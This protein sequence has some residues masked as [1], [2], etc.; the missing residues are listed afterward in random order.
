MPGREMD[1]AVVGSGISGLSAAWLLSKRHRV[2]VYEAAARPG[3]HSNTVEVGGVAV[4]TGFI[5][6]N[7]TTYPNLTALF[8][9]L[10]VP[11][12]A[13]EMSFAVSLDNGGL[14]YAGTDLFGLFG[15]K[16]NVVRPRFWSMLADLRRFYAEAPA[17]VA[18]LPA[19]TTL[20]TFLDSEGYGQA[21][22]L[23]H[24]LP[25]AAAIWSA[26]AETLRDYP[27][28][29]FIRFCANHGLLKFTDR[30][31]WRTVDG[32]SREYV[33]RLL[34][35]IG[36]IRLARGAVSVRRSLGSVAVRDAMGSEQRFDHV[37]MACHAD[38]ALAALEAPTARERTLLGAF[39]Y[40]QN[41][42]V[43]HSDV[44][45][46]PKRRNVWAS[47]NYLGGRNHAGS[48][49]VTYWMNRLQGLAG[50]PPLFVTLN[51]A[52]E[53]AGDTVLREEIYEHPRFDTAA[54]RA[55]DSLWSLQGVE[56]TWFCGAYFGSGFHEDGLQSGLAVA[57]QL[58]GVRRPWTVANESGRITV[59]P[60]RVME[61]AA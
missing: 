18:A 49:H 16:R 56:R 10:N 27:A 13:S 14:E 9:H 3:G 19:G 40:T 36:E 60:V 59:T 29:H 46:M 54:M 30:P 53:P 26:S 37:V 22:Q 34:T 4:D 23:D 55:Q 28:A 52:V 1:I 32:G 58:G 15:Q 47:W 8:G 5:V 20:G 42:A 61:M 41:R 24:L 25:M 17:K 21:F 45:L 51:P 43:L 6:Y 2:T 44:R 35:E 31:I 33:R 12:K 11:T 50:T 38:Q 48:L 39:G 7:E 57:E